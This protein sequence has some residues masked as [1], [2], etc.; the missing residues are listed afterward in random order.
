MLELQLLG[1]KVLLKPCAEL[2][3]TV[4]ETI[5]DEEANEGKDPIV[6]VMITKEVE[7]EVLTDIQAAEVIGI[8]TDPMIPCK[9]GQVVYYHIKSTVPFD[10]I[11]GSMLVKYYDLIAIKK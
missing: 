3:I 1:G 7:R 5:L 6:D 4:T 8:G 11:Q 2:K 9:V 10:H